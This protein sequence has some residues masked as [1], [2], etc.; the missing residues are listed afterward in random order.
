MAL[1]LVT[2]DFGVAASCAERIGVMYGGRLMEMAPAAEIFGDHRMRYTE[3]LLRAIPRID[4]PLGT[5]LEAIAG[6]TPDPL[7]LPSG[8][9]FHPRCA[10]ASQPCAAEMPVSTEAGLGHWYKCWNPVERGIAVA[11]GR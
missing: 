8:C 3:A 9:P 6:Q 5:R 7:H 11:G 2:H 10:A 4:Q 1:I